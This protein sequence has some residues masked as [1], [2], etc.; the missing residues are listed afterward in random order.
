MIP[1][2]TFK[3]TLYGVFFAENSAYYEAFSR[4]KKL[5]FSALNETTRA[6]LEQVNLNSY[7]L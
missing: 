5:K 2:L 6:V 3:Y 1:L 7:H 4:Q